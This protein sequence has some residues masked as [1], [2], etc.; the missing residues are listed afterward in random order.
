MNHPFDSLAFA[1]E[2]MECG[3]PER[4]A[5]GL[6]K[7]MWTLIDGHLAT[8]ADLASMEERL[9][10]QIWQLRVE[11]KAE[12]VAMEE[13]FDRKLEKVRAELL[14]WMFGVMVVQTGV[15]AVLFKLLR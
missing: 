7:A 4:Q 14:Q 10:A 9:L 1:D 11:L 12:M 2:L 6:A 8:K 15:I 3:F 5:K 13:R